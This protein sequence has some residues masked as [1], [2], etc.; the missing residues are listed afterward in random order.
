[1]L[2]EK[3]HFMIIHNSC[4]EN[5][6]L[7]LLHTKYL[8]KCVFQSFVFKSIR[9]PNSIRFI[10]CFLIHIT[11]GK[12]HILFDFHVFDMKYKYYYV[13]CIFLGKLKNEFEFNNYN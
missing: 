4:S 9:L 8:F 7:D 10:S 3:T 5:P 11:Y 12:Y 6:L 13:K 2:T 1:M